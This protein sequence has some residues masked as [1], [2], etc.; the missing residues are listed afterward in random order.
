MLLFA[1][2]NIITNLKR[3]NTNGV[4]GLRM[5][6]EGGFHRIKLIEWNYKY[7]ALIF[8]YPSMRWG[9]ENGRGGRVP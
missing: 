6:G 4:E 1:V 3:E 9:I 2:S 7:N 8:L 5:E